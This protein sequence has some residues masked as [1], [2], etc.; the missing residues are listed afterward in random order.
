MNCSY[1][2]L[3]LLWNSSEH[4]EYHRYRQE[5][6]DGVYMV[7]RQYFTDFSFLGS[8]AIGTLHRVMLESA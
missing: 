4:K 5:Y 1:Q 7:K 8:G 2:E 3:I 6:F